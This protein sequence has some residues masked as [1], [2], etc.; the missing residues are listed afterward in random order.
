ML[1]SAHLTLFCYKSLFLGARKP[2]QFHLYTSTAKTLTSPSTGFSLE[3]IQVCF[4][5]SSNQYIYWLLS[6]VYTGKRSNQSLYLILSGVYTGMLS[7]QSLY[8]VLSWVHTGILSKQSLYWIIF[9]VYTGILSNQSLYWILSGV[10]TGILSNQSL[11]SPST[12]FSLEY[13]CTGKLSN[14]TLTS[15]STGF[16]LENIQVRFLTWLRKLE[17]E[18]VKNSW[19][20]SRRPGLFRGNWSWS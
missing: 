11:T 13:I 8:W 12:G 7:N 17:P 15:P 9:G 4:L 16:S 6:G 1:E 18:P 5:T 2:F 20:G 10:Y 19:D 3:Y 14:Q